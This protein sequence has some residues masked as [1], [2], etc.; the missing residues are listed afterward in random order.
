LLPENN[1]K[2]PETYFRDIRDPDTRSRR[3]F[4]FHKPETLI[5][6]SSKSDTLRSRLKNMPSKYPLT[7]EGLRD[8]Q[9]EAIQN[10]EQS[11]A[12]ARQR[13]LIQSAT[14]SGKT[15]T[16]VSFIYR[17]IKFAG[18]KRILFLVDRSNLGR[19][20]K[21]EFQQYV[22][23]DDGRKF[24]ELYNVQHLTSNTIDPGCKVCITTIQRLYSMLSGEEEF[25]PEN[26]E[27][28][29][30][31]ISPDGKAKEVPYNPKIPIETFDFIVTDECHRSIYGVWRQILEYFDAFIIGLTRNFACFK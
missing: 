14:G 12:D 18:A 3:T 19:Q 28:S 16:G 23:P 26:E 21:K 31:E 17:L 10:L 8:C 2:S 27:Q 24:T 1:K 13:A 9:F 11:F 20:T 4:S 25:E 22:T 5:E 6:W 15:Y 29:L 30:F 7:R